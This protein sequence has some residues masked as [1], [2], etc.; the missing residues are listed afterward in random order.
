MILDQEFIHH[1]SG[2]KVLFQGVVYNEDI[3]LASMAMKV[4]VICHSTGPIL[5]TNSLVV[6]R[7]QRKSKNACVVGVIVGVLS[8]R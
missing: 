3:M 8:V 5:M 2:S 7:I 1:A 4:H 6:G